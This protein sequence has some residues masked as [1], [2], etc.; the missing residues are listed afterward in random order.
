MEFLFFEP[1]PL[2]FWGRNTPRKCRGTQ[3]GGNHPGGLRGVLSQLTLP[4]LGAAVRDV[5]DEHG[6]KS[7]AHRQI[8]GGGPQNGSFSFWCPFKNGLTW[9]TLTRSSRFER[10]ER[11]GTLFLFLQSTLVGEPCPQKGVRKGTTGGPS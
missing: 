6:L 2:D 7:F 10:L 9:L 1:R 5:V 11:V 8:P 4:L 3:G